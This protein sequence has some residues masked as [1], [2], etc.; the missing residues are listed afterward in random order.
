MNNISNAWMP[1]LLQHWLSLQ[2]PLNE[3][4]LIRVL[5]TIKIISNRISPTMLLPNGPLLCAK[6]VTILVVAR[7]KNPRGIGWRFFC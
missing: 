4:P 7:Q 5:E 3:G 1:T 6:Y 2:T